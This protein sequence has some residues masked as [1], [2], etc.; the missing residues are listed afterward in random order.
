[1]DTNI[2]K[3]IEAFSVPTFLRLCGGQ[4]K[5]EFTWHES[6]EEARIHVLGDLASYRCG[7]H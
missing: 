5:K 3:T 6:Q 4:C 1:M 2:H 7:N